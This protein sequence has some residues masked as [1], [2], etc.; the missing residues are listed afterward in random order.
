MNSGIKELATRAYSYNKL[1][2]FCGKWLRAKRCN[3]LLVTSCSQTSIY[4]VDELW[5]QRSA[6]HQETINIWLCCK[7]FAVFRCYRTSIQNS[8]RL[9]HISTNVVSQPFAY[10]VVHFLRL[11]WA[12]HFA[13]SDCPDWFICDHNSFPVVSVLDVISDGLEL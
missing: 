13:S 9:G 1:S 6:T 8:D 5:F 4:D 3:L 7:F 11:G 2:L 12:C 10:A